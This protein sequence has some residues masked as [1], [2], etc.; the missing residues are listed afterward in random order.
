MVVSEYPEVIDGRTRLITM[1]IL[2]SEDAASDGS[3]D[4]YG[5]AL[6]EEDGSGSV[7]AGVG[8]G[9]TESGTKELEEVQQDVKY[10]SL[11]SYML[12]P[13]S[14]LTQIFNNNNKAQEKLFN[15]M[16]NF[17]A[18][19]EWRNGRRAVSSYLDVEIRNHQ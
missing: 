5:A 11:S 13:T 7:E 19:A 6:D 16:C 17:W 2:D 18:W 1:D 9:V 15:H 14:L 12:K 8:T 4:N 3:I 10:S